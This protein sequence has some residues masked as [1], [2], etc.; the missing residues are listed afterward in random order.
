MYA[1][2]FLSVDTLSPAGICLPGCRK[3]ICRWR[4]SRRNTR[5]PPSS[6]GREGPWSVCAVTPHNCRHSEMRC[7][8][9][10]ECEPC[11][12][13]PLCVCD[14]LPPRQWFSHSSCS[15]LSL[16]SSP[17]L[18]SPAAAL[19]L[20]SSSRTETTNKPPRVQCYSAVQTVYYPRFLLRG[21]EYDDDVIVPTTG[22]CC[23]G[24]VRGVSAALH[25]ERLLPR[26]AHHP[27]ILPDL[28]V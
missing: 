24:G 10:G 14:T 13:R 2:G 18:F 6:P 21:E 12:R 16:R 4:R 3:P 17:H 20:S 15:A 11:T 5:L 23:V 22:A 9:K 26:S 25:G 1:P 7:E 19:S 8:P 27:H 28:V